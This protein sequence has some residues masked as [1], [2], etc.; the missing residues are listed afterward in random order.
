M[1]H[2]AT[3]CNTLQHTATHRN[4]LQHTVTR[5][6]TL[7][8]TVTHCNTLQHTVPRFN[9]LLQHT[10]TYCNILQH[11]FNILQHTAPPAIHCNT[12]SSSAAAAVV[13]L[14][15]IEGSHGRKQP[16]SNA[17]QRACRVKKALNNPVV[18]ATISHV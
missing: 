10:A 11:T 7:Q 5:C 14:G 6:N 9:T 15:A 4:T 18:F 16:A 12:P 13:S 1:Q 3:Y 8:H 2:T 17:N